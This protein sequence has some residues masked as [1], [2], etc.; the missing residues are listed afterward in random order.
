MARI[1]QQRVILIG[2]G[3]ALVLVA[4][5]A[6]VL[7]TGVGRPGAPPTPTSPYTAQAL[8][9]GEEAVLNSYGWVDRKAGIARI[10][11]NRA[12]AIVAAKGLPSRPTPTP[13]ADQDEQLAP[14][15]S[16]SGTQPRH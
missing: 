16:S 3:V 7:V 2:I 1:R 9:P 4:L 5:V 13:P 12:I 15:Y 14:S 10:P 6:A 8:L 11:I